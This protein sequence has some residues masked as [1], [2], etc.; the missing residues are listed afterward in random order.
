M[1]LAQSIHMTTTILQCVTNSLSTV[2]HNTADLE[3]EILFFVGDDSTVNCGGDLILRNW[4]EVNLLTNAQLSTAI[5]TELSAQ[6]TQALEIQMESLQELSKEGLLTSA[7]AQHSITALATFLETESFQ[8]VVNNVANEVVQELVLKQRMEFRLGDRSI[9]NVGND[10]LVTNEAAIN[11]ILQVWISTVIDTV[12]EF[13]AFTEFYSSMT[14]TQ[15]QDVKGLSTAA[16]VVMILAVTAVI[17]SLIFASKNNKTL[18]IALIILLVVVLLP[19]LYFTLAAAFFWPPFEEPPPT[20]VPKP[21]DDINCRWLPPAVVTLPN[22]DQ[23]LGHAVACQDLA[24]SDGYTVL[25]TMEGLEDG[26]VVPFPED[27][28]I[29]RQECVPSPPPNCTMD[30]EPEEIVLK[31]G[32]E[33]WCHRIKCQGQ[34]CSQ[35]GCYWVTDEDGNPLAFNDNLPPKQTCEPDPNFDPDELPDGPNEECPLS[36]IA[37]VQ[38]DGQPVTCWSALD[39]D[40]C[41]GDPHVLSCY[42]LVD[43]QGK[44]IEEWDE[45][46]IARQ[47][48]AEDFKPT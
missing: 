48:C 17:I 13:S 10:C 32:K 7:D 39:C 30:G 22:G 43:Q 47:T 4:A 6:L 12:A 44:Q 21:E 9:V 20:V 27:G 19:G 5:G 24:C 2:I 34:L 28:S 14:A 26:D 33:A 38:L 25:T 36:A 23:A 35:D 31:D 1:I 8:S 18:S 45:S 41:P 11:S 42:K 3:Q 16:W 29:P 40:S 37:T 15:T 46:Q